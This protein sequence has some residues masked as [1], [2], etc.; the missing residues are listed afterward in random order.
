M[1]GK[2]K[3]DSCRATKGVQEVNMKRQCVQRQGVKLDVLADAIGANVIGT[4]SGQTVG[5][6]VVCTVGSLTVSAY[7]ISAVSGKTIGTNM[8]GA[9]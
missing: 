2:K 8:I 4:V 3:P 6:D 9:V 1:Q 5:A 7:V